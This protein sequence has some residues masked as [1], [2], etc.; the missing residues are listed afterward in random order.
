MTA[1]EFADFLT[2]MLDGEADAQTG[3]KVTAYGL[4]IVASVPAGA[5]VVMAEYDP[6]DAPT[7]YYRVTVE[8]IDL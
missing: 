3:A 4:G 6:D 2:S 1:Q 5:S 8:R 7:S